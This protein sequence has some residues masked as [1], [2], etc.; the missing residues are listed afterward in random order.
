MSFTLSALRVTRHIIRSRTANRV[1]VTAMESAVFKAYQELSIAAWSRVEGLAA[2]LPQHDWSQT[3]PSEDFD[4]FRYCGDYDASSRSQHIYMGAVDYVIKVPSD[5]LTGTLCYVESVSASLSG[6]RWLSGGAVIAVIPTAS[7]S[8]PTWNDVLT[9]VTKSAALMAVT[10]SNTGPDS[11]LFTTLNLPEST[12]ATAYL[13]VILRLDDYE[14][15]RGAWVEGGALLDVDA[16]SVTYSRV[17]D[18]DADVF[19]V[20]QVDGALRNSY[21]I[22][23]DNRLTFKV[24]GAT[25]G[26]T[27]INKA[28][29][30]LE[31]WQSGMFGFL[32]A[33]MI[34]AALGGEHLVGAKV[35]EDSG[36]YEVL[37]FFNKVWARSFVFS[38]PGEILSVSWDTE[39]APSAVDAFRYGVAAYIVPS[40]QTVLPD[41][42]CGNIMSDVEL[43]FG[44]DGNISWL[45]GSR[46]T[47][48]FTGSSLR[49][50][51][52]IASASAILEPGETLASLPIRAPLARTYTL[53]VC[54][55]PIGILKLPGSDV[56]EYGAS[57]NPGAF[58]LS[59]NQKR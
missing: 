19:A 6:D 33:T 27:V 41:G 7:P 58:Y 36:G 28:G 47:I 40:F 30:S 5:A 21:S 37:H 25:S 20:K 49:T 22:Y 57:W 13:H 39:F 32:N 34:V 17:V 42:I 8:P 48:N 23:S 31:E 38:N 24:A 3:D 35:T 4:A 50:Y 54:A 15:H 9:A 1:S 18:A 51:N 56:S 11:T 53:F 44:D 12:A 10:P 29:S 46:E 26:A 45:T 59:V 55:G 52:V 43:G 14:T 16:L 2:N